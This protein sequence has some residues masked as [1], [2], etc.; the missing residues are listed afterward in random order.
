MHLVYREVSSLTGLDV[1]VQFHA[2]GT[3]YRKARQNLQYFISMRKA[4]KVNSSAS[5]RCM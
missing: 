1:D 2:T 3:F 4:R 5:T